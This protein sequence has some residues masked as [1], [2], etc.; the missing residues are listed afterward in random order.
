M[1]ESSSTIFANGMAFLFAGAIP[2][3]ALTLPVVERDHLAG[4]AKLISVP[5]KLYDS[6]A[7][8]WI[9]TRPGIDGLPTPETIWDP[10][11]ERNRHVLQKT[12]TPPGWPGRIAFRLDKQ[13]VTG[14][15]TNKCSG[16]LVGPKFGLTAAHCVNYR[17]QEEIESAWVSDS[18]FVRPGFDRAQDIP[19][20]NDPSIRMQPVRVMRSWIPRSAF[21]YS[22]DHGF[23]YSGDDD[24]AILELERDVGTDLG[25][26]AVGPLKPGDQERRFHFLSYP[27]RP[28]CGTTTY[29]DTV[30]R[31]DSLSH[32]YTPVNLNYWDPSM[33]DF[34][35]IW[36]PLVVSWF[37]E[38]GAGFLDCPDEKCASGRISVRGTRWTSE[39]I[40]AIDSIA[41]GVISTLL[42]DV[43]I[44]S[45]IHSRPESMGFAL[46]ASGGALHGRA[47]V[48]GQWQILSLDGRLISSP[49]AGQTFLIPLEN[50]PNGVALIVF[51]APGQAPVTRRWVGR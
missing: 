17:A 45:S 49:G 18:L 42:K 3:F 41:S 30:S 15:L 20:A 21:A 29:C 7:G 50:A 43:K 35:Q 16:I 23:G 5:Y 6:S 33:A 37:G 26:A 11:F 1:G 4:T 13:N 19:T 10:P 24:W 2:S 14:S 38:S 48:A 27:D 12:D 34:S 40:S 25:W 28:Q 36:Q 44:P 31:R 9:G 39:V 22:A 47:D 8:S 32:S 51:R 46:S